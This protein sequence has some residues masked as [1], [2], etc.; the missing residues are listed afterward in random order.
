[1]GNLINDIFKRYSKGQATVTEQKAVNLYFDNLQETP[2]L[3]HH[4]LTEE[5][6]NMLLSKIENRIARKSRKPY[7]SVAVAAV[8]V[9]VLSGVF[10]TFF[11]APQQVAM[12]TVAAQ[13]G[14]QQKVVLPD[15]SVV[16]LNS[17]SS[18]SYPVAFG[19]KSRE[20][21]LTGE[22]Y[23]EVEHKE[24]HPFIITSDH[25]KTQ[26]LGT[27]FVV[28][29][30]AGDTPAVTVVSGKVKVTDKESNDS[31]IITKG[32]RVVYNHKTASLV[33]SNTA[34][35]QD[36]LA[37][38]EGRIFFDHAD[39]KQV[40]QTLHRRYNVAFQL[41]SPLY[42]CNTISGNFTGND[43]NKVLNSIRFI[44]GLEYNQ[45][46]NDTIKITLKPCKN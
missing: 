37:W 32:Q 29:N 6:G 26:V 43:V 41:T 40:L 36:Y 11:M 20:V 22:A 39:M 14:Q 3:D 42:E 7:W 17:G 45:S 44:N 1:M 34:N 4:S 5:T 13:L 21:I 12:K 46:Q 23:F 19:E 16:Y 27:K 38:K 30:Y 8:A 25:L 18:I 9:L 28:S 15:A 33:K 2:S 10:Y 24:K 35:T 31:E